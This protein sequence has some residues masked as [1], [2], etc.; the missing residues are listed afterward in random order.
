M[1]TQQIKHLRLVFCP[2][3]I[4][5]IKHMVEVTS[6][7]Y[8]PLPPTIGSR[9]GGVPPTP[10]FFNNSGAPVV[11]RP[12]P[13]ING[14]P[15]SAGDQLVGILGRLLLLPEWAGF[16]V[17]VLTSPGLVLLTTFIYTRDALRTR[18]ANPPNRAVLRCRTD[19]FTLMVGPG[20]I[21]PP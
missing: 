9:Q 14:A 12:F 18:S 6:Q 8:R 20:L 17:Q 21:C 2:D 19:R 3:C 5:G 13:N 16:D 7:T 11:L 15:A 1:R 4:A 10:T